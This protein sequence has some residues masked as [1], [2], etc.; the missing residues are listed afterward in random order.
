MQASTTPMKA[1]NSSRVVCMASQ[2][3]GAK[4]QRHRRRRLAA[5]WQASRAEV[6]NQKPKVI[7]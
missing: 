3:R 1:C 4:Q 6:I 5:S 7:G 2:R